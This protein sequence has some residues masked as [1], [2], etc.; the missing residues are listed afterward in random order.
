MQTAEVLT[1]PATNT[2]TVGVSQAV[3]DI[4]R[5]GGLYA[6]GESY[7]RGEWTTPDLVGVMYRLV[8]QDPQLAPSFKKLSPRFI[9]YVVMD[10]LV[11]SQVG[12]KA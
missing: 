9:K 3:L 8:T 12:R 5:R 1:H 11:N 4:V 2:D 10:R 6:L 7:M